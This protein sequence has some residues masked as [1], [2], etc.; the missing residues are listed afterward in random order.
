MKGGTSLR[1]DAVKRLPARSLG[2]ASSIYLCYL[3]GRR[4]FPGFLQQGPEFSQ[5]LQIFSGAD[6]L[7]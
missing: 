4:C 7:G 2:V 3:A 5:E 1:P 6:K